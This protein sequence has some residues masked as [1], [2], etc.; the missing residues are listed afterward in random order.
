[1]VI[2]ASHPKSLETSSLC[3][4]V[5]SASWAPP[6]LECS[7]TSLTLPAVPALCW[8]R[9]D[10]KKGEHMSLRPGHPRL[11]WVSVSPA[12]DSLR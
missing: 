2:N 3:W 12:G 11:Y 1:V 6:S 7:R 9:Q 4:F 10:A 5:E 8:R